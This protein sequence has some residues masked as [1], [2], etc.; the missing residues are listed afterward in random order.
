MSPLPWI[1]INLGCGSEH[2]AGAV[3]LDVSPD[4]GADVVWDL[5]TG[6]WPF[7]DETAHVIM[8]QDVFEHV[9]EPVLFMTECHRIL[10]P[11][12][13]L[14]IKVPHW[15]HQDAYTDPTH[16]RFCTPHTFDYWI[17]GTELHRLHGRAYGGCNFDSVSIQQDQSAILVHLVRR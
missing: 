5:D 10:I 14:L 2:V 9:D 13:A 17:T 8:A 4:V 7:E 6:P 3:N 16:R 15:R 11:G 1:K 12:G